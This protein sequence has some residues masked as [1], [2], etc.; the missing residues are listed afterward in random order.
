VSRRHTPTHRTLLG[1]LVCA[2]LFACGSGKGESTAVNDTAQGGN[3]GMVTSEADPEPGLPPAESASGN[4]GEVFEFLAALPGAALPEGCE[5]HET[6]SGLRY[7]V[8]QDGEGGQACM[9]NDTVSVNYTGYFED[10]QIFDQTRPETGPASFGVGGVIPGW[11]EALKLMT[12]GTKLKVFIPWTLAYGEQGYPGAIPG[13]TNLVFDM[14]LLS[15]KRGPRPMELP[16]FI[17]PS[18]EQ[19]TTTASGLQYMVVEP[20]EGDKPVAT[21]RVTV[22]YAGWLTDGTAFDN[23]YQRGEPSSFGLRQVIKGWTEGVQ[24]MSPGGVYVFVI[25]HGLAYGP[26]GRPPVIPPSS[27]LVFR[28][29]LLSIDG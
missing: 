10:G 24:L 13:R 6:A 12:P 8:I 23:S 17:L 22:H 15:V 9:G 26:G 28:I 5:V 20:G 7:A 3:D 27:T 14:D 21:D 18:E 19:L 1:L 29:E 2:T 25:P 16:D 4:D 11:T